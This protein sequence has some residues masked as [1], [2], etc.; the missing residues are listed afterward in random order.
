MSPKVGG[1]TCARFRLQI[2]GDRSHCRLATINGLQTD[3]STRTLVHVNVPKARPNSNPITDISLV[4][5]TVC[6]REKCRLKLKAIDTTSILAF[7]PLSR[8]SFSSAAPV[9]FL[10]IFLGR[11]LR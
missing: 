3:D 1:G 5:C 7:W 6:G 11:L 2:W 4:Q 8:Y 9:G 10:H